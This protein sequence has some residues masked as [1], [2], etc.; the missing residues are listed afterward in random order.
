[1]TL[2]PA[3]VQVAD[4]LRQLYSEKLAKLRRFG[5][6][7]FKG[8]TKKMLLASRIEIVQ[9]MKDSKRGMYLF[10]AL[11]VQ[12]QAVMILHAIELIETQG[13]STLDKYLTKFGEDPEQRRAGK[14]LMKDERWVEVEASA[15]ELRVVEHR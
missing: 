9:R 3:Y 14:A 4:K 12:S 13:A 11:L 6:L 8:V 2:P 10:G 7:R 5:F 15:K 1:V